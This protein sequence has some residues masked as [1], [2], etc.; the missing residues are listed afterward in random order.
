MKSPLKTVDLVCRAIR[1]LESVVFFLVASATSLQFFIGS[2]SLAAR[3]ALLS[4]LQI[5]L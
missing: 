4:V 2:A 1:T 3:T 5:A